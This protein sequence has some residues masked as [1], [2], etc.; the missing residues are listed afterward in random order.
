MA[1]SRM[2][3]HTRAQP[4]PAAA[5]PPGQSE[6]T[7][8]HTRRRRAATDVRRGLCGSPQPRLRSRLQTE[9]ATPV[10]CPVSVGP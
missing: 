7:R 2:R 5:A 9:Y 6:A 8:R 4:T 3:K 1:E 10:L